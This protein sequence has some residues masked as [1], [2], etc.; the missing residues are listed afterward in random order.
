M[1]TPGNPMTVQ[2]RAKT[3]VD[4]DVAIVGA[5]PAGAA[6]AC[7]FARAGF[8]VVLIDQ[9][10]FPRDKVCGDFVG[11][12]ALEE[13]DRLGLFSQQT[14]A[15]AAK[16]R[17]GALYVNG[18]KVVGQPF[19][20]IG[21]FRDYGLCIPRMLLDEA[22]VQAAVA[23]G[24]RLIE[25]ARVIGYEADR[26]GV[27]VFHKHN[28]SPERL[29]TRLL[30]GADGSSSL[31]SRSL[32]AANPAKRDRIVAVRAYFEGVEGRTDQADIYVNSSSFPGY[33]WLFPTGADTANVG[34]GIPLE[35]WTATKHQQLGKLFADYI[36]SNPAMRC[37]LAKAKMRGKIAGWPL[38]TFN[39]RTPAIGNRVVLIGDAA[40]LINPLSG[41]GIQYALRS[42][43]WC[44]ETL[45]SAVS[46]DDLSAHGLRPYA[47]RTQAEM[48]Y[49]MA[50]SRLIV[51][52]LK[53]H[54]L[55]P[56]WLSALEKIAKRG[57]SHSER[58]DVAAGVFAGLVPA[59]DLLSLSF[60][61]H[62]A[63][64]GALIS[65]TAATEVLFGPRALDDGS[66]TSADTA[67]SVFK[68]SVLHPIATLEWGVDCALSAFELAKQMAMSS[69]PSKDPTDYSAPLA[70][71]VNVENDGN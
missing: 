16:I 56:L 1:A 59:R 27:T 15:N 3:S 51:D 24:T 53:N 14:F 32:R 21:S 52:L 42:A 30:I 44:S 55:I 10:R 26:T 48:R 65:A 71:K 62:T 67:A 34:V 58:Y 8:R 2:V 40:G 47:I 38:T 22:I 45:M 46:G 60:L 6:A 50:L 35:T 25:E 13:L 33:Y 9:R 43:R 70:G 61:W 41:E 28:D 49:D 19:P 11:P 17:N 23:S 29:R 31:I 39:S 64:W 5:G 57:P 12:A 20:S 4:A 54:A 7:H 63:K 69:R 18:D 68:D 66:T 36:E 37:R